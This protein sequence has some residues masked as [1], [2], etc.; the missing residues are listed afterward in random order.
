MKI[1]LLKLLSL[2]LTIPVAANNPPRLGG[3]GARSVIPR[4]TLTDNLQNNV[5]LFR[6]TCYG[7]PD[8]HHQKVTWDEYSY[9]INGKRLM[10]F[11]GEVHPYRYVI[12]WN[13]PSHTYS[14]CILETLFKVCTSMFSRRSSRLHLYY[15]MFPIHQ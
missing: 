10:L 13:I 4:Q 11:S 7:C 8:H 9:M 12:R 2:V 5:S 1:L 6:R 15:V 3:R 14:S